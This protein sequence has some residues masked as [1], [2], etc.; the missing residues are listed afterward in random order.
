[1]IALAAPTVAQADGDPA[2]DVLATQS[3]FIPWDTHVSAAQVAQLESLLSSAA[4]DGLPIR[5][6]LIASPADL[7]SVTALWR[8]PVAYA[9]FLDQELSLVYR[10]RVLVEMPD[11]VGLAQDGRPL[12]LPGSVSPPGA[13]ITRAE[14]LVQGLAGAEGHHLQ[15]GALSS[16][17]AQPPGSAKTPLGA[18]AF[19]IGVILIAVTWGMSLH[20]RP[21]QGRIRRLLSF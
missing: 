9:V 12:R 17:H 1:M 20:A 5:V 2:S 10:G 15:L 14:S 18:L 11:G 19:V 3:A 4:H 13:L 16:A 8:Q 7:G 21:P 6:A